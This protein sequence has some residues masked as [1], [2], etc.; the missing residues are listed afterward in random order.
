MKAK[1]RGSLS[2]NLDEKKVFL[3]LVDLGLP[4]AWRREAIRKW[5]KFVFEETTCRK[6]KFV[7]RSSASI[8]GNA[9]SLRKIHV[10]HSP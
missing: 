1:I 3:R 4:G 5:K 6:Q 9:W 10:T 8:M 2:E 7:R